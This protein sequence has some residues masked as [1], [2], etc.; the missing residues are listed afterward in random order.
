MISLVTMLTL[1]LC[2]NVLWVYVSVFIVFSSFL[3]NLIACWYGGAFVI[4]HCVIMAYLGV[5]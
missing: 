2:N 4:V 5:V 1:L 3:G